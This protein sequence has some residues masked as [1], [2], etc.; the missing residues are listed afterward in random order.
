M[1][2]CSSI[3]DVDYSAG[4]A[5]AGLIHSVHENGGVFALAKAD[6]ELISTL[7]HV[8]NDGRV[9]QRPHLLDHC[10]RRLRLPSQQPDRHRRGRTPGYRLDTPD[11]RLST[12][13]SPQIPQRIGACDD[14]AIGGELMVALAKTKTRWSP[15]GSVPDP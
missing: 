7:S 3:A 10:R 2:D 13:P 14:G 11:L 6:P 5:L 12:R 9:R 15:S 1:L 8:R 4:L